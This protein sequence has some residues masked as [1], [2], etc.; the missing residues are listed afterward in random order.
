MGESQYCLKKVQKMNNIFMH[1][2]AHIQQLNIASL[3]QEFIKKVSYIIY[4]AAKIHYIRKT[5]TYELPKIAYLWINCTVT[6]EPETISF[7]LMHPGYCNIS[8][9]M[10]E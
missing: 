10:A 8:K 9:Q 5:A 3:I 7:T 4:W 1:K 6:H 2:I